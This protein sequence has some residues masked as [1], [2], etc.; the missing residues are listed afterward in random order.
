MFFESELNSKLE[1][2]DCDPT[3][4][5]MDDFDLIEE[6]ICYSNITH[7]GIPKL[8]QI[9]EKNNIISENLPLWYGNKINPSETDYYHLLFYVNHEELFQEYENYKCYLFDAIISFLCKFDNLELFKRNKK[10]KYLIEIF[11]SESKNV[12]IFC[13]EGE[14]CLKISMKIFKKFFK[15]NV[16]LISLFLCEWDYNMLFEIFNRLKN[17]NIDDEFKK[18]MLEFQSPILKSNADL[19]EILTHTQIL[20]P[21]KYITGTAC[22][23]KTTLLEKLKE[24]YPHLQ[25]FSRG[26]LGGFSRKNGCPATISAMDTVLEHFLRLDGCLGD[27]GAIDNLVWRLIMSEIEGSDSVEVVKKITSRLELL[28]NDAVI[29]AF[30]SHKVVVIIDQDS[31]QN[32]LRMI[33]RNKAN[34]FQRSRIQTYS[35]L[36]SFVYYL[37]AKIFNWHLIFTPYN[38]KNEFSPEFYKNHISEISNYFG[39][40]EKISKPINILT[41][42]SNVPFCNNIELNN[43][44]N[45]KNL[46]IYK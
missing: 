21:C 44:E 19:K 40:L 33:Q 5:V 23:G 35:F 43:M 9:F 4:S 28:L 31:K 14:P 39:N 32:L 45:A 8:L 38:E 22:V 46:G 18:I 16:N 7:K 30:A 3:K 15:T 11:E 29:C 34:D 25:V 42:T 37:V 17:N 2:M 36:Q 20:Q 41:K 10:L 6:N 26:K 1:N 27:R 12:A 13:C 24:F